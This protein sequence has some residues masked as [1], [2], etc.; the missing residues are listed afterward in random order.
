MR[1]Q[2]EGCVSNVTQL[3]ADW[4]WYCHCGEQLSVEWELPALVA[5]CCPNCDATIAVATQLDET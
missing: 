2:E 4:R 3:P 1:T 5:L